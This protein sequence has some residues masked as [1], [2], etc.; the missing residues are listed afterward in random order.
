MC[1][2]EKGKKKIPKIDLQMVPAPSVCGKLSLGKVI[3]TICTP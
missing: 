2:Q 3:E 1:A